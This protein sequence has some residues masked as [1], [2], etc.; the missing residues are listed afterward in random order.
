MTLL[1]SFFDT[2]MSNCHLSVDYI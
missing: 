1:N 2:K